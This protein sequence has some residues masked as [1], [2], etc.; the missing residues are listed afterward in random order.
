MDG[1]TVSPWLWIPLL[2]VVGFLVTARI[3]YVFDVNDPAPPS[4]EVDMGSEAWAVFMGA[5]WPLIVL[6]GFFWGI[7]KGFMFIMRLTLFAPTRQQRLE[8]ARKLAEE[9]EKRLSA[10]L[11]CHYRDCGNSTGHRP[12]MGGE[13]K[14]RGDNR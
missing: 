8:R 13:V 12:V 9:R 5:I 2:Y 10:H 1:R 6:I 7:G 11:D 14:P 3:S 4:M